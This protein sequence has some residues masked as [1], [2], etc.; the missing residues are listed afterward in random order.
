[1]G[2][3]GDETPAPDRSLQ[4]GRGL[5]E[6]LSQVLLPVLSVVF[7]VSSAEYL[8]WYS[9]ELGAEWFAVLG[10]TAL[11]GAAGC[12][13]AALVYAVA[14][15]RIASAAGIALVFAPFAHHFSLLV[16]TGGL[17]VATGLV[18]VAAFAGSWWA[19][20]G[21]LRPI[22]HAAALLAFSAA[23]IV[24]LAAQPEERPGSHADHPD[25]II[26]VIDTVRPD[27]L[28]PYGYSSDTTPRL[29]TFAEGAEVYEDAW[30]VSPWTA[31]SHASMLTGLLPAQHRIDGRNRPPFP[32][33]VTAI[34]DP[35][36]AAGYR[37]AGFVANAQIRG[38]GWAERFDTYM[39]A[40]YTGKH[41]LTTAINHQ[42]YDAT[43]RG[44]NLS[45]FV[46]ERS[47]KWWAAH[48]DSPRFLLLNVVD[49]HYYYWPP[50]SLIDK[51]L[52]GYERDELAAV[53]QR[54]T[55]Y[56]YDPG[57]SERA[58]GILKG[59]YDGELES[60]DSQ[61]GEFFD[62]LAERGELDDTIVVVTSDHGERLGERGLVGHR[63]LM[64][65]YVLRVP[66][67]VRYGSRL[68]AR[69]VERRVQ[70]DG[71]PGYILHLAGVEGPDAMTRSALDQQEREVAVAQLQNPA[72]QLDEISKL[73]PNF[74][75]T[76]FLGDA[77]FL[78]DQRYALSWRWRGENEAEFELFDLQNDAELTNDV[79]ADHP[80]V[81][82]RLS[83]IARA[84]PRFK[85]A[86]EQ[87]LDD[88]EAEQLRAL[89]Y[90]H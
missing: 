82:A 41:T 27:H 81:V 51:Y 66:L 37:T 86:E 72:Y 17:L 19:S 6:L 25:V 43:M 20:I 57:I 30:S 59:L 8:F 13:V 11:L 34:M 35:L 3:P 90:I 1:M 39:P 23:S 74:D 54:S 32:E 36:V 75:R 87:E 29:R 83:E 7:A 2:Q 4:T 10:W 88:D 80:E 52:P 69:R 42:R 64:D 33:D 85:E 45:S 24:Y 76:P 49:P 63:V 22:G 48:D 9:R 38:K 70:L 68:E 18:L 60:I 67:I 47:R 26:L 46:F 65:P 55:A 79:A 56:H 16:N 15:A 21:K 50:D 61:V 77:I 44:W 5:G 14:G 31:P 78:A 53:E 28:S 73:G 89:G 84:L 40:W 71:L 58:A 62:W 12:L